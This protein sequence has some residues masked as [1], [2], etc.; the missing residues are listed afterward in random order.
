M[1]NTTIESLHEDIDVLKRE[2][3]LIRHLLAE[4]FELSEKA[5]KEL[6]KARATPKERYTCHEDVKNRF[7]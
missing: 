7:L 5:K 2:V 1:Q 3:I 6:A 4:D